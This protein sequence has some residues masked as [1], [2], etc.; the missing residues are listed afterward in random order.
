[1]NFF[2]DISLAQTN[3]MA[4]SCSIS[5][6]RVWCM[7]MTQSPAKLI[8]IEINGCSVI[9]ENYRPNCLAG[10]LNGKNCEDGINP[11]ICNCNL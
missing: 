1:M 7:D 6:F 5:S 10:N 2:E 9:C 8:P 11:S 3:T 4:M